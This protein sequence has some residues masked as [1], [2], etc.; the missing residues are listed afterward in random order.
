MD[1]ETHSSRCLRGIAKDVLA[2]Q[3][4]VVV[5]YAFVE[6]FSDLGA[7]DTASGCT[8]KTADQSAS[9]TAHGST[10]RACNDAYGHADATSG[11]GATDAGHAAGNRSNRTACTTAKVA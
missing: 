1:A 4:L 2:F 6:D 11:E 3:A 5:E 8:D 10:S 7:G 9:Q